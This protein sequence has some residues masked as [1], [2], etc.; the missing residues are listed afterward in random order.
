MEAGSDPCAGQGR[1]RCAA[2]A[3]PGAQQGAGAAEGPLGSRAGSGACWGRG[4]LRPGISRAC[5]AACDGLHAHTFTYALRLPAGSD[6]APHTCARCP[7]PCPQASDP[8]QRPAEAG[9][10]SK[11]ALEPFDLARF[12]GQDGLVQGFLFKPKTCLP[13]W[14]KGI[15]DEGLLGRMADKMRAQMLSQLRPLS[16]NADASDAQFLG[17]RGIMKAM[18]ISD[19]DDPL[20]ASLNLR[21]SNIFASFM[22]NHDGSR[23]CACGQ[24]AQRSGPGARR[25]ACLH[26]CRAAPH[27]PP[28]P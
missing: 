20:F 5:A 9:A 1:R 11:Y 6:P 24:V 26:A 10:R 7:S 22:L 14:S 8:A 27:A 28:P 18:G 15:S 3:E 19:V 13:A 25:P 23:H 4:E 16:R 17:T 21:L 2:R 12:L